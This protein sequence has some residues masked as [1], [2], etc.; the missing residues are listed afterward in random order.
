MAAQNE[1]VIDL[2]NSFTLVDHQ[3]MKGVI[4]DLE[5]YTNSGTQTEQFTST[6]RQAKSS[7][8]ARPKASKRP[9]FYDLCTPENKVITHIVIFCYQLFPPT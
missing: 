9:S 2:T 7:E 6:Q 8:N 5:S 4:I 3:N 1:D